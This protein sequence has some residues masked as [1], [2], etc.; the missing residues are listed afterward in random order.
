[1]SGYVLK[2]AESE[3]DWVL[4]WAN[5]YLEPGEYVDADMGWSILPVDSD[6]DLRIEAQSVDRTTSQA[7]LSRG[8]PGKF[9]MVSARIRTDQ[10]RMLERSVVM[11]VAA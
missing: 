8:I 11:R 4:S 2:R 1:M 10:G 3:L 7:V 9:Y 6:N 5:G